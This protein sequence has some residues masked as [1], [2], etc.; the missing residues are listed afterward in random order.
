MKICY[1]IEDDY[2]LG[3]EHWFIVRYTV[4]DPSHDTGMLGH[5]IKTTFMKGDLFDIPFPIGNPD[6]PV[7]DKVTAL[8]TNRADNHQVPNIGWWIS[9]NY[10]GSGIDF[11]E[12]YRVLYRAMYDDIE[13]DDFL[14]SFVYK[15]RGTPGSQPWGFSM[16]GSPG[17]H[18]EL[19]ETSLCKSP[20]I[21]PPSKLRIK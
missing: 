11:G 12:A 6:R 2:K 8:I 21:K 19:G 14:I 18:D 20:G 17:Q 9:I 10:D 1:K 16:A 5:G 4:V 7:F 3:R 15:R 13:M